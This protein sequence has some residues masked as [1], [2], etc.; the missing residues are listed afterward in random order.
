M[1]SSI[2]P[3]IKSCTNLG[4]IYC[5][6]VSIFLC[7]F[8]LWVF[9][10]AVKAQ[11]LV[12]AFRGLPITDS[13]IPLMTAF[14]GPVIRS[15][16]LFLFNSGALVSSTIVLEVTSLEVLETTKFGPFNMFDFSCVP[17][18]GFVKINDLEVGI[19]KGSEKVKYVF[20]VLL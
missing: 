1:S 18:N 12:T 16:D 4:S 13:T 10:M 3:Q 19:R 20:G 6:L 7:T 5:S 14:I 8:C 17:A 2:M 9:S 11:V 15:S